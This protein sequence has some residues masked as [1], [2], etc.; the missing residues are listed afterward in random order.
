MNEIYPLG[1][2][3]FIAFD[4]ET[5]GLDGDRGEIIEI[6]A[7]LVMGGEITREFSTLVRPKGR[8]PINI[9]HITGISED[10]V[11]DAPAENEALE[12]FIEFIDDSP[13]IAHNVEFDIG[14]IRKRL[15]AWELPN[16]L[17]QTYDSLAMARVLYP[18]LVNH[19]LG[20]VAGLFGLE[21]PDA[22]RAMG[23]AMTLAGITGYLWQRWLALPKSI[24]EQIAHL[25]RYSAMPGMADLSRAA[26]DIRGKVD[27]A[28]PV[29]NTDFL[30]DLTNHIG[31]KVPGRKPFDRSDVRRALSDTGPLPKFLDNFNEREIQIEMAGRVTDAF[32]EGQYLLAEAG[33]GTGKSFAYLIPSILFSRSEGRKVVISTKTKNLQEQLF[34]KD[35]PVLFRAMGRDFKAV[36]L[37]GRGNYVCRF[38]FER[39]MAD[40]DRL[41]FSESDAFS[42]MVVWLWETQSGDVVENTTFSG[43][44]NRFL[45]NKLISDGKSCAGRRCPF[46]DECFVNKVRK[47]SAEADIVVVNHALLF[48]DVEAGSILGEYEH[49]VIDEAHALEKAAADHFSDQVNIWRFRGPSEQLFT[50]YPKQGGAIP[51][52]IKRMEDIEGPSGHMSDRMEELKEKIETL[53]DKAEYTFTR[54]SAIMEKKYHWKSKPYSVRERYDAYNPVFS[55]A[56]PLF[57]ELAGE[58]LEII[59]S[60][61]VFLGEVPD[62]DDMLHRFAGE[63]RSAMDRFTELASSLTVLLNPHEQHERVLWMESPTR[64]D[65]D[66]SSLCFAPLDIDELVHR[67]L[68][69]PRSS[70]VLTSAT[71]SIAGNFSYIRNRLGFD[72]SGEERVETFIMDSPFDFSSQLRFVVPMWMEMPNSPGYTQTVSQ[73]MRELSLK[74]RRGTLGLF[75]SYAMLRGVYEDIAPDLE[76]EGISV[77]AQRLTGSRSALTRSFREDPESVLLGTE[78][79]WE[80]VDVPGESLEILIL[81]KLPFAVPT[82]PYVAAQMERIK[83]NGG[84]SF[85]D[86]QVPEAVIKFRQGLGRLIRS[87]GDYGVLVVPDK[88]LVMKRYGRLFVDSAPVPLIRAHSLD[89]MIKILTDHL[90]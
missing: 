69:E 49:V 76:S 19:K 80:G 44:S 51:D 46:Y 78:S 64:N 42:A 90:A 8:I 7:V 5:T 35:I 24:V 26:R 82:D 83:Q 15:M 86:Y 50:D 52:I 85:M 39:F 40:P 31:K 62:E 33:T 55:E 11:E 6:A 81:T 60:L 54:L 88:R 58:I 41:S 74:L 2:S 73:M 12:Q 10:M 77:L 63:A 28:E 87:E 43:G 1:L 65:R 71:L 61:E 47:S 59:D 22:H 48:S 13:L 27:I 32:I 30:V 53:K 37:K 18:R 4:I 56:K 66:D 75:T 14:F 21:N 70:V 68:L 57:E 23:D 36:L 84:N 89:D 67:F 45:W 3:E 79:F 34:F 38:R 17:N 25:L 16:I 72:L 29:I 20:T 9:Q